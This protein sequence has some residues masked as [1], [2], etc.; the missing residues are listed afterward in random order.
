MIVDAFW[1]ASALVPLCVEQI[2]H[3]T[4]SQSLLEKYAIS[5][6]WGTQVEIVSALTRLL[7]AGALTHPEFIRSRTEMRRISD[8]WQAVTPSDRVAML[9]QDLLERHPLRAGDALQL[10]AAMVWC[11]ESPKGEVFITTDRRL[12]E[13]AAQ[14]GFALES[15]VV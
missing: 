10:A 9:A 1:D 14:L 13:A 2:P 5:A 12:A 3:T 8:N 4:K 11:E 6:W 7:R 15:Q